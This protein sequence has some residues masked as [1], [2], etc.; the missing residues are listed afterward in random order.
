MNWLSVQMDAAIIAG[1]VSLNISL[2]V[3]LVVIVLAHRKARHNLK[4]EFAAEGVALLGM[5]FRQ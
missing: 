5:E 1:V 4:L 2:I 3:A